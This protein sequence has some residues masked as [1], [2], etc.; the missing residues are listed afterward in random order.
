MVGT[1]EKSKDTDILSSCGPKN[2]TRGPRMRKASKGVIV[3]NRDRLPRKTGVSLVWRFLRQKGK[4]KVYGRYD[5]TV[6]EEDS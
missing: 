5:S 6:G 2:I 3:S 1:K 4:G